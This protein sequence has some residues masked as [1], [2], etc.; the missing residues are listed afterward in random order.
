MTARQEKHG[1]KRYG[2]VRAAHHDS[3]GRGR[4]TVF[5]IW[6]IVIR[7]AAI[8]VPAFFIF[9][10]AFWL[11][12]RIFRHYGYH[13]GPYAVY[14]TGV[15]AA[16]LLMTLGGIVV[17]RIAAPRQRRFFQLLIDAI[18]QMAKGNFD[19][20]IPVEMVHD[21]GGE[22]HPFRQL[23]YSINDMAEELAQMEELR[24]EFIS[25]VSHEIQSPLT[26]I[27]GFVQALK[28]DDLTKEQ[29][30][31]YLDIIE[32]ESKRLSRLSDN[33][34]KLTSLESGRHPFHPE[35]YRLDRQIREVVLSCE[36]LWI[37]KELQLDVSL[38]PVEV[39]AD[40]DLVGQ[41]WMNLLNNAIKFT[42]RHGTIAISLQTEDEWAVVRIADTGIG[43]AE[44]DLPRIFERFYKADKART[45][46]T[47]GNGLGL[48]IVKK[49][50]DVHHG[51]I[52]V[53]SRLGEGTA[54]TVRLPLKF[55]PF[56][57]A[58]QNIP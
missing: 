19:V 11:T 48:A 47:P 18:R 30:L 2:T 3:S 7:V 49:I 54:F 27:A 36:P 52:S 44:E 22:N 15:M 9:L 26:A 41:V 57:G 40:K 42:G 23:V 45:R 24:Q 56:P 12:E 35:A 58:G 53:K 10:L 39:V 32:T 17:G 16:F 1:N 37:Q 38:P 21:P 14:M 50:V 34:L 5:S 29:R 13:P 55:R 31:H 33:L 51:D 25:N 6:G 4:R 20:R 46:T 43:I 28:N 8:I